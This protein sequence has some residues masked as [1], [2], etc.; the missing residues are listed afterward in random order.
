MQLIG[1]KFSMWFLGHCRW[2][3]SFVCIIYGHHMGSQVAGQ[4]I[5][6]QRLCSFSAV[7]V[8]SPQPIVEIIQRTCRVCIQ[9][10]HW[11]CECCAIFECQVPLYI[12]KS[13]LGP[14]CQACWSFGTTRAAMTACFLLFCLS[15]K[16][17]YVALSLGV[18]CLKLVLVVLSFHIQH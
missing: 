4:G 12:R 15:C 11:P 6:I 16:W 17:R 5:S 18:Y 7:T 13:S 10:V 8:Q 3:C 1:L 14:Y 9:M 2:L